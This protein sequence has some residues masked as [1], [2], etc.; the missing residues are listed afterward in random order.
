MAGQATLLS[1]RCD[2]NLD[3]HIWSIE[4]LRSAQEEDT[5]ISC[6]LQLMKQTQEKPPWESVALH[7]H[8]VRVLWSMW[9]R[10][11]VHDGVL[12]RRFETPDGIS[13]K[14]QDRQVCVAIETA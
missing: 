1:S 10:L 13:V 9:S 8:G 11:R 6:I 2:D 14:W 4:G 7:S 12:Q 3:T 5:D